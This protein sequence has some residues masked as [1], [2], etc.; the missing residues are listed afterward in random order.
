MSSYRFTV[1]ALTILLLPAVKPALADCAEMLQHDMKRLHSNETVNLCSEFGGK[2]LLVVNTASHCG[3]TPQFESLEALHQQF[4]DRGV[5]FLGVA[6]N[7]FNQ[8]ASSEAKTAEVCYV[9][10][11]V[12]F[13]MTAPVPVTGSDAHPLFREL[14]AQT[15][16]PRWNFNKYVVDGDGQV[17]AA[18]DSATQ[19]DDPA[20][21]DL[22]DRLLTDG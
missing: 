17:V 14:S 16:P 2:P 4:R 13:T 7:S 12:S 3:F 22:L 11:G 19:P 21:V 1:L 20:I 5:G 8:E 15:R 10:Y 9:N 6:S 18:F